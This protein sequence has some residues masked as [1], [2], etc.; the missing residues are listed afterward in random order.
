MAPGTTCSAPSLTSTASS[1]RPNEAGLLN[2]VEPVV[3]RS[4]ILLDL[5]S[6]SQREIARHSSSID[7]DAAHPIG[8]MLRAAVLYADRLVL[9]DSQVFDGSLLLELGPEGLADLLGYGHRTKA[10]SVSLRAQTATESLSQLRA[11]PGFEWQVDTLGWPSAL[12][13]RRQSAW[14]RAIDDGKVA[15][16]VRASVLDFADQL[17]Q[18]LVDSTPAVAPALVR[19]L[20]GEEGSGPVTNR[21]AMRGMVADHSGSEGERNV[22]RDWW[23]AAYMDVIAVQHGAYWIGSAKPRKEPAPSVTE[24]YRARFESL[25]VTDEISSVAVER[26]SQLSGGE[27]AALRSSIRPIQDSQRDSPSALNRLRLRVAVLDG[28]KRSRPVWEF[29][30]SIGRVV[31]WIGVLLLVLVD[32]STLATWVLAVGSVVGIIVQAP[33]VELDVLRRS[34][35]RQTR[36]FV[37]DPVGG[38]A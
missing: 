2:R 10:V 4:A 25:R 31:A 20:L 38:R 23:D 33:L 8:G 14:A 16:T 5:D 29:I 6:I 22:I 35:S 28:T 17:R 37:R 7:D 21:S 36:A 34:F 24:G 9:T 32:T 26:L 27:F 1:E 30:Q 18:R 3:S 11:S 12:V 19:R 15:H 13:E